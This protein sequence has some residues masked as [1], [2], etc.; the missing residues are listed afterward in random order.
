MTSNQFFVPRLEPGAPR[1][2]LEGEEHHHLFRVARIR[3]GQTVRLFDGQGHSCLARVESVSSGKTLLHVLEMEKGEESGLHLTLA[4]GL[5][6]SKKMEFVIQ[7]AAEL[8]ISEFIPLETARSL[9]GAG[10]KSRRKAER[11]ERIAREAVKQ[12]KGTAV[13]VVRE[14]TPFNDFVAVA[15]KDGRSFHLSERGGRPLK[16][17]LRAG[18]VSE[19]DSP[20]R[21]VLAVGPEGGWTEEEEEEFRARGFETVS[22]GRRIL[23]SET[24]ALAA[25]AMAIHFWSR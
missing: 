7:K 21:A 12:S 17:F 8:G 19:S 4:L 3:A 10:V 13:P 2:L 11:W 15:P 24:A 22:L 14:T 25:T 6:A 9:R 20:V 23:K 18:L 5:M 16:D 1:I